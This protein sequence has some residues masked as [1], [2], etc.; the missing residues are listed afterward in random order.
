[1]LAYLATKNQF[2]EDAPL[3]EDRVADAVK[4]QLGLRVSKSEYESW[5]NSLGNAMAHVMRTPLI[6]DDASVAVEYRLNGR[7]FRLDFVVAGKNAQGDEALVVIELKQWAE[8]EFSDL[9]EH[10][11]T[12]LGGGIHEVLHPSYQVWSYKSHLEQFNEYIYSN[13]VKVS[14]CAY[15]HNC[16]NS[17]VISDS[18]YE[19]ALAQ[20]PVFL[21]G[22][23]KKL[24]ELIGS[25]INTGADLDL[26]RRVDSSTIRPS[27]Q[28]ADAIGNMLHG[29]DEFVLID[30]QKTV[31]EK[32]MNFSKKSLQGNKQVLIIKGG[33][34]TGKSVISINALAALTKL[35]LNAR[36]I[37]ANSAPRTVFQAKLKGLVK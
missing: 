1:M 11:R 29:Q 16:K 34:G 28:L 30:E 26:M 23:H 7:K 15:L 3:I 24:Q 25:Q 21:H 20:A 18:L 6:P 32:I 10:V 2:L 8:I 31:F 22:D 12:A 9:H 5:R 35:Q 13:D 4:S 14:A 19:N 36:Y 33:P 27:K 37:T 17:N